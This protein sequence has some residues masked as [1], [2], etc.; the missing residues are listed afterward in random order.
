MKRR[1]KELKYVLVILIVV[2]IIVSIIFIAWLYSPNNVDEIFSVDQSFI[3]NGDF[4]TG[5][6]TGWGYS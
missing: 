3:E 4:E 1:Y 5:S 2:S 6:L